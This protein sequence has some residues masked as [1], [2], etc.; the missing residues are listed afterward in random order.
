MKNE[1]QPERKSSTWKWIFGCGFLF[2]FAGAVVILVLVLYVFRS[3]TRDPKSIEEIAQSIVRFDMPA[4]YEYKLGFRPPFLPFRGASFGKQEGSAY[5]YFCVVVYAEKSEADLEEVEQ[6]ASD[7]F[8]F[9]QGGWKMTLESS[10]PVKLEVG[11]RTVQA[12]R[13]VEKDP[14]SG[15]K[16]VKYTVVLKRPGGIVL[17]LLRDREE[18]FDEGAMESF[19]DSVR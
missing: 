19:L 6:E 14:R 5:D 15:S 7:K 2:L 18:G 11:G 10:E 8:E 12:M 3:V 17:I 9:S 16:Y 13:R 4:G 1:S